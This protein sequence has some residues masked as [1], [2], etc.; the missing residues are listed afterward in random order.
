LFYFIGMSLYQS[1]KELQ[2][3]CSFIEDGLT[4]SDLYSLQ[5]GQRILISSISGAKLINAPCLF[6]HIDDEYLKTYYYF[7]PLDLEYLYAR[8]GI[9][10]YNISEYNEIWCAKYSLSKRYTW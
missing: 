9:G 4:L 6:E 5:P 10:Y 2:Y 7:P 3:K 8:N 1:L